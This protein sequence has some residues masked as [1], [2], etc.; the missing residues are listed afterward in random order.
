MK[1]SP[2]VKKAPLLL[3]LISLLIASSWPRRFILPVSAQPTKIPLS[4]SQITQSSP[5]A[6]DFNGNGYKEIVVGGQDG[7]LYVVAFD[8]SSWSVVWSRQVALDINAANPPTPHADNIIVS[9]PAVGDLD[10]DGQLEIVVTVGGGPHYPD[11]SARRNGGVL[12][13]RYD[14][15]WHFSV[16]EQARYNSATGRCEDRSGEWRGWPQPCIDQI[17]A[18]PGEGYPDGVWDGLETTPALADLDGDGDMEIIVNSLDR[19]IHAFNHDGQVV[20]GWPISQW[21]GDDLWRGGISSPA[22]GDIDEDGESEVVVGTMSPYVNGQQDQNSTLWAVNGDGTTVPGF[23]VKTE[24]HIHSSPAL[25]DITG[26]GH[27]EIVV[28]VGRGIVAG[29]QNIVYAWRHD[30][31]PLPD[32]PQETMN[33]MLAPP[34]LGDVDGDGQLEVLIGG[35]DCEAPL[36]TDNYFYAWDGNGVPLPGFPTRPP[37]PNYGS[38][39]YPMCYSPVL[40]DLDGDGAVE[41]LIAPLGAWGIVTIGADGS[42]DVA[43]TT[44]GALYSSP[45]IED[46]DNDG[47][48][49]MVIGGE[50]FFR[51]SKGALW[52]WSGN[53]TTEAPHPWPMFHHDAQRTGL[54][55]NPPTLGFP[56]GISIFHQSGSGTEAIG[57]VRL[58]NAGTEGFEWEL[59][60]STAAIQVAPASGILTDTASIEVTLETEGLEQGWA[61]MGT[62]T[63]NATANG[64]AIAGSPSTATVHL[65]IGDVS[66]S[67][68]PLTLR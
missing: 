59:T 13:Y 41:I 19:R 40:A 5:A 23:P 7:M 36:T 14:Y 26:D 51:E 54:I 43:H 42:T 11:F 45:L 39:S 8:G 48:I 21:N 47:L 31:T 1:G 52:V 3:T 62:I 28:G 50:D 27:L 55:P 64:E 9:S 38:Q 16:G 18:G 30:G 4:G 12:V 25:G 57:Q 49:E 35:G 15:Q 22:V 66:H 68:L 60:P 20:Q 58:W 67:Y 53:G 17:G 65:F 37:T 46:I 34:A 63:A 32:W 29:R 24:Q 33:P 56:D 44:S 6:A 10:N 2:N 61:E